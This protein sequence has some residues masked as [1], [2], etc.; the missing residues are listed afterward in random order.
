MRPLAVLLLLLAPA[1]RASSLDVEV[2]ARAFEP[3]E[4]VRVDV[5]GPGPLA[6]VEGTLKGEP[7]AF[8][9]AASG[10]WSAWGVLDLDWEPGALAVLVQGKS[11][12]GASVSGRAELQLLAKSFPLSELKV[13]SKYVHPPKEVQARIEREQ[14][15]LAKVYARRSPLPEAPFS[16]VRPVAGEPTS[17]FGARRVF[18][19][20]KRAPHSGLDLRAPTGTP[21]LA[22]GTGTVALAQDLYYSGL[23][24]I[25]DHGGG[26]FTVYAHLS[27]LD[28][29]EGSLAAPGE[30]VGLS[31]ATGR[32]TG[33]HL[34]WGGKVGKRIFDP[35]GLLDDAFAP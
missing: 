3:G 2:R 25:L 8:V 29:K 22:A 21:V 19:G 14:A 26:L 27:R 11:R 13:E 4:L 34:H 20:E 6:S 28:V 18:N 35:T 30:R 1:A 15:L 16:W 24:V 33:P 31:G 5:S 23:T 32:V 10:A 7:L 12:D 17:V 9:E